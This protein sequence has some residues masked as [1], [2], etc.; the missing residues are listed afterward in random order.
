ALSF[1]GNIINKR[2]IS[3]FFLDRVLR[4]YPV[5]LLIHL[6]IFIVGPIIGYKWMSGISFEDYIL[7]FFSNLF[8]LPGMFPLPIAQIVAWSLSYEAVFYVIAG[9]L[10]S[11]HRGLLTNKYLKYLLYSLAVSG[12]AA[13][14]YVR[15]LTLFFLV[16]IGV[17]LL[18]PMIKSLWKRPNIFYFN[19]VIWLALIYASYTFENINIIVPLTLSLL[20]FSSI[21]TEYGL[22][23]KLLRSRIMRY[24]GEISYSLYMWHTVVMFPLK[25]VMQ[26]ISIYVQNASWTFLIYAVLCTGLSLVVSHLSYKYIEKRLTGYVRQLW[27]GK[28]KDAT[29]LMP[30]G[31]H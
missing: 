30:S 1:S 29:S 10:Y 19:S 11:L 2:T 16:G 8:L 20:F 13:I 9:S 14:I 23:P 4:I 7:N 31:F 5:F 12:C 17:F 21:I 26:Q 24:L 18:E 22:L 25:K 28:K 6:F 15:P 3:L 27:F